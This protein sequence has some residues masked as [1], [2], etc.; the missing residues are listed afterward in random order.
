[1]SLIL[2]V[3]GR[4]DSGKT[5][6]L[7]EQIVGLKRRGYTVTAVKHSGGHFQLDHPGKDSWRTA[8]A[9][10][11][12]VVLASP[13]G[14]AY[15]QETSHPPALKTCSTFSVTRMISFLLRVSRRAAHRRSKSIE[16]SLAVW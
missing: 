2:S 16:R 11:D 1:M 10:S 4:S 14:R 5:T 13:N 7:E 3:V 12:A 6:L 15:L 9:A 8:N